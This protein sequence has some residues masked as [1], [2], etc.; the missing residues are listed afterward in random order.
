MGWK[1]NSPSRVWM[2]S[3]WL[4]GQAPGATSVMRSSGALDEHNDEWIG[5]AEQRVGP[6]PPAAMGRLGGGR[7]EVQW[8]EG[9]GY[10]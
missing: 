10:S 2:T 9:D 7:G 8:R 5:Q 1:Q 4:G 6:Q 3:I